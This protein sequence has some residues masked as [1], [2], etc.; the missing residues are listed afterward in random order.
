MSASLFPDL[1][2]PRSGK[3]AYRRRAQSVILRR[4]LRGM[5]VT[6]DDVH[7]FVPCPEDIDVNNLGVAFFT[8]AKAGIIIPVRFCNSMRS[9]RHAGI[10]RTWRIADAKAG[11]A[12]LK[13]L[14]S[15]GDDCYV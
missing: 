14:A 2:I 11:R 10:H 12:Y 3:D 8:L 13:A 6:A 9:V 5:E 4:A 7:A 1:V 15:T